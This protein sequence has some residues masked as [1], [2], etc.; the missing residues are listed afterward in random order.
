LKQEY[1]AFFLVVR[2]FLDGSKEWNGIE[3][4]MFSIFYN[5]SGFFECFEKSAET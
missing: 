1:Q 5:I 2:M 4:R 3:G